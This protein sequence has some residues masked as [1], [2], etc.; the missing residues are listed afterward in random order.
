[1]GWSRNY[2]SPTLILSCSM[3]IWFWWIYLLP[4][5]MLRHEHEWKIDLICHPLLTAP[6]PTPFDRE[7]PE[8]RPNST[9]ELDSD[10]HPSET[11]VCLVPTTSTSV[12]NDRCYCSWHIIRFKSG[13]AT[14][15]MCLHKK[16]YS[17]YSKIIV[18]RTSFLVKKINNICCSNDNNLRMEEI[19]TLPANI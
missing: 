2:K 4:P 5:P 19:Y 3:S 15:C 17:L 10:E 13:S 16:R 14:E 1:M 8:A 12:V 9:Q 7:R 18:I 11:W 6:E